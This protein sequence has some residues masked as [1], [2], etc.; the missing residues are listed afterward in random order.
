MVLIEVELN[1]YSEHSLVLND[2]TKVKNVFHLVVFA[3]IV[4]TS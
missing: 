2:Q 3:Y 1:L 4:L